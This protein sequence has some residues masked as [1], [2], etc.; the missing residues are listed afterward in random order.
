MKHLF[1]SYDLALRAK[2]KGFNEPCFRYYNKDTEESTGIERWMSNNLYSPFVNTSESGNVAAPLYQQLIDWFREEHEMEIYCVKQIEEEDE[3]GA[4]LGWKGVEDYHDK[5]C[6]K[7]YYS[8]LN[9]A[10]SEAFKLI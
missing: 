4:I 7:D 9:R 6:E 8:A 1:V 5:Y 10:I 2:E 3:Y